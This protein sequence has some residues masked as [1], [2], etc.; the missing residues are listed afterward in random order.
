MQ[1]THCCIHTRQMRVC[2]ALVKVSHETCAKSL[3]LPWLTPGPFLGTRTILPP[4][5]SVA[6]SSSLTT[7]A[8]TFPYINVSSDEHSALFSTP[9]FDIWPY[10]SG[11]NPSSVPA[12]DPNTTFWQ[13]PNVSNVQQNLIASPS[14]Q[15]YVVQPINQATTP[16]TTSAG[17]QALSVAPPGFRAINAQTARRNMQDYPSP[18][19][20]DVSGQGDPSYAAFHTKMMA[21]PSAA[22]L[23]K[24][25]SA[26]GSSSSLR[27]I[28]RFREP[29]R[30]A[31]GAYICDDLSCAHDPPT[32]VR[33]CEW[34]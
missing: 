12:F 27:T 25:P 14:Y 34:T 16:H 33:K 24:S 21:S 18:Q 26:S 1:I 2:G 10:S 11:I 4:G 17:Q 20:S 31:Q 28:E 6:T 7:S 19:L 3:D 9:S 13:E 15:T 5:S 30:D 23:L 29:Q 32:F 22:S 8:S